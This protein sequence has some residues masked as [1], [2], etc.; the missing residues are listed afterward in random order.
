MEKVDQAGLE[1]V[2]T[3]ED[4]D[5]KKTET[6]DTLHN[7][8]ALRVLAHYDGDQHWSEQEEKKLVRKIDRKLV[9][10]LCITYGL[11][12]YD[13]AMLAQAVRSLQTLRCH[14]SRLLLMLR[15][16]TLRSSN[17]SAPYNRQPLL[18]VRGNLLPRLHRRRLSRYLNGAA[19]ADRAS[20]IRNRR[21]VG[22]MPDVHR[23]LSQLAGHL[24]TT[25]LPRIS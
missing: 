18:D 20:G 3:S 24:R 21:R 10:I 19:L 22:R 13:K 14:L 5:L 15:T 7:D 2:M 25:V 12:Y 9:T 16:G 11:Q 1:K 8:E 17:G 6:V 4:V 23:R